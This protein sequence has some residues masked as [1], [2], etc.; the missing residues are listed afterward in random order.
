MS[1]V[2]FALGRATGWVVAPVFGLVSFVRHARTFHPSGPTFHAAVRL[3]AQTPE[4]LR[5]LGSRLAGH[6]L[7]RFSGAL[8]K[9]TETRLDVLGCAI[10]L[11]HDELETPE[12]ALDDQ[13]LLFATIKRPW[14]MPFAPFTTDVR[15]YLG[16]DYFAVSPFD[17]GL[18]RTIYFRLH[19]L[20]HS[21]FSARHQRDT[22]SVRLARDVAHGTA[23]LVLDVG[24]GPFG[25]W[26]PLLTLSL[27]RLA[28][29]DGEALRFRPFRDGR[30]VRPRGF[31]HA[32]RLG[33]YSLSQRAR[34][35]DASA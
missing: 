5:E 6:A 33:V 16:N 26:R 28:N 24:T 22:R 18:D 29:V 9:H 35:K 3:H 32:L 7:V 4:E 17:A 8:W 25:P 11:R 20:M 27:E 12:P 15:D 10:R 19:P 1:A 34:P 14:T 13:D 21:E 2:G 30:G 23:A 31:V